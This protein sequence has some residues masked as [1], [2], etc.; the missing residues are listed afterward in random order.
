M[1]DIFI[2]EGKGQGR[3]SHEKTGTEIELMLPQ[4]KELQ[5]PPEAGRG[6]GGIFP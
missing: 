1:I 6:K 2:K 3:Q 5:E 4:A